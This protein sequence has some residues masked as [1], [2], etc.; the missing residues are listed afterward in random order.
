MKNVAVLTKDGGLDGSREF[1]IHGKEKM[2]MAGGRPVVSRG[3]GEGAGC[4]W[5]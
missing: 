4:S 1:A 2:L 3:G 5:N